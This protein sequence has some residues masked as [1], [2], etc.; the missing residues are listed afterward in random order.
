MTTTDDEI[1]MQR[2][3]QLAGK[4]LG[5][6]APNPMVGA[7]LVLEGKIIGEGFHQK[8]GKP[9]AEV[10][11][12]TAANPSLIKHATLYVN[13]EPCNHHGK[14]PPCTDLII[15][16]KIKNVVVGCIDPYHEMKGK[17]IETLKANGINVTLGICEADC[18]ELNKRFFTVIEKKDLILF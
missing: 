2:C 8:F 9:H 6:V 17:G 13:L 11:A 7:V 14:T 1:F 3:L 18:L 15:H 12:I 4:G 16:N 5:S 10:N